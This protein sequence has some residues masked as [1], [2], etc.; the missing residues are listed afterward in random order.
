MNEICLHVVFY[1]SYLD[2]IELSQSML[3][4]FDQIW[5]ISILYLFIYIYIYMYI[6]KHIYGASLKQPIVV[7]IFILSHGVIMV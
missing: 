6:H 2:L 3:L 7:D 5:N 1:Q 4:A